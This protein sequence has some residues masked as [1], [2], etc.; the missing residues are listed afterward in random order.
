MMDCRAGACHWLPLL[1]GKE[2]DFA[3]MCVNDMHT[4]CI[5]KSMCV[6]SK[7]VFT[8]LL[9]LSAEECFAASWPHKVTVAHCRPLHTPHCQSQPQRQFTTSQDEKKLN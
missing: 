6:Q 8:D 3:F 1:R 4:S 7:A 5:C 2:A 9:S